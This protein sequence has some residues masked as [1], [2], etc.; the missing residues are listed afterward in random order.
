VKPGVAIVRSIVL[1]G[2][3]TEDELLAG[4]T[5]ALT[6]GGWTWTHLIRS[7]GVT[8]GNA[9]LPDVIACHPERPW[10]LAWELKG[11]RGV[12]SHDQLRWLLSLASVPG[13]DARV[14]RPSDYDRALG[15]I[16]KGWPPYTTWPTQADP[17]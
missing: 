11:E 6:F 3:M 16:L 5:E 2:S 8:M 4:I 7:D 14:I 9:G 15:V 13:V 17:A 1:G 10:V 12:V